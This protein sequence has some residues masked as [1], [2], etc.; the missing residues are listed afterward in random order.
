M[1]EQSVTLD[2]GESKLVSFEAIPHEARTYQVKVDGLTGSFK[3]MAPPESSALLTSYQQALNEAYLAV[4]G[5]YPSNWVMIPGYGLQSASA[6]IPQLEGLMTVEAIAIGMIASAADRYFVR[7]V[8]YFSDGTTIVPYWWPC[9][10]CPEKFRS[11]ALRD[12]H[13]AASH[14]IP[15]AVIVEYGF[16]T[17]CFDPPFC[18]DVNPTAIFVTWRNDSDFNVQGHIDLE[19]RPTF[20]GTSYF[21]SPDVV[22]A[23]GQVIR[24]SWPAD[25]YGQFASIT[26]TVDGFVVDVKP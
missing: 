17:Y 4:E 10:Y 2:P 7:D 19:F 23:P 16:D 6:A 15:E 25:Y 11:P 8:M 22:A 9:P 12:A 24:A 26:L 20:G 5:G 3:A 1:A 18:D 14:V 21:T 13:I